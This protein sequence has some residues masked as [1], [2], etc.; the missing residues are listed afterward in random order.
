MAVSPDGTR[1]ALGQQ[2]GTVRLWNPKTP[3]QMGV[4]K[5]HGGPIHSLDISPDGN[6]LACGVGW[7]GGGEVRVWEL[8]DTKNSKP[9]KQENQVY[10]VAFGPDARTIVAGGYGGFLTVSKLSLNDWKAEALPRY[11]NTITGLAVSPDGR[12]LASAHEDGTI[13][14]R[15]LDAPRERPPQRIPLGRPGNKLTQVVY[16]PE[17]RHLLVVDDTGLCYLLRLKEWAAKPDH[18]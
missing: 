10:A 1:F 16:S 17:G 6:W 12:F 7:P 13:H 3:F 4:L 5:G 11:A 15:S 2:S 9:L 14:M 18:R 8:A